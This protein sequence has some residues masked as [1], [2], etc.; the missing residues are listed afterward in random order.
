MNIHSS[1]KWW[2]TLKSVVFG[3]SSSLPLLISEGDEQ[4][5]ESVGKTDLLS[6]HFD[7]KHSREAVHLPLTCHP[8]RS[9]AIFALRSSE[10]SLMLDLD[11]YG[12]PD[13]LGMFPIFLKRTA[14][15]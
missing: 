5:C 15:V 2:S 12:G 1:H 7:R 4:V 11:T 10:V 14:D 8:F 13:P 6:Y 3:S 9:L